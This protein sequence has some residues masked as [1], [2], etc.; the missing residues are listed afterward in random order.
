[1]KI[2]DEI[3]SATK[4]HTFIGT[5]FGIDLLWFE[6]LI[7]RQLKKKNVRKFLLFGD[8]DE[9]SDNL[10]SVSDKLLN[11]GNSYIIQPI[12]LSGRFHPKIFILFGETKIRLYIGSGNITRG[13][14]GKKQGGF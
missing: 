7:L 6:S 14:V 8:A 4:F 10:K 5:S 9:L 3:I 12:K 11:S 1:M 2:L 13:G